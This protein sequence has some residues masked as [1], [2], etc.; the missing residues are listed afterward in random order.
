VNDDRRPSGAIDR[1]RKMTGEGCLA[2]PINAVYSDHGRVTTCTEISGEELKPPTQ[3]FC[4]T[5]I[6]SAE[7]HADSGRSGR[8]VRE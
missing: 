3:G 8:F 1:A 5:G 7:Q 2:R 4:H 6:L